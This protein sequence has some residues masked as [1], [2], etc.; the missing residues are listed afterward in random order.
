MW[1]IALGGAA[2]GSLALA[3][4]IVILEPRAGATI[5]RESPS[6]PV[7][8]SRIGF[9]SE[10]RVT[11][12]TGVIRPREEVEL[13][14]RVPGKVVLRAVEVGDKVVKGQVVARLDD[15]D[16]RLQLELSLAE[17]DAAKTDQ[18]RAKADFD[19]GRVLFAKGHIS[20][21][22]LDRLES[23][24]AE[25]ASRADR[26]ARAAELA[27]NQ[28]GYTT[29]LAE[30]DGVVTAT[31]AEEGE[32]V[33]A[34]RPVASVAKGDAADVVFALP[35]QDRALVDT[36]V[37]QAEIWGAE[38]Q[39]YALTLR[40]ISPDVDPTGRTYRVRMA[41]VAP[42]PAV[43]FGRTVTVTLTIGADAPS[44]PVPLAAILNDG[45]GA[46][47]WRIDATGSRVERVDVRL[48]SVQ[49]QVAHVQGGLTDGD[50]I[51]SLGAHKIDPDRP[52]RVVE[53]YAT[54]ES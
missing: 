26:A 19:R 33:S 39:D 30:A 34:G 23:G 27:R 14:F 49:G 5:A 28:L 20:Q 10:S 13:G 2:L 43:A 4:E 40:D 52:V 6:Q 22:A 1:L 47:V 45:S 32:V 17:Q 29:L 21:A 25:A 37:A 53:T 35:E 54:P 38:G 48:V 50:T 3:S 15:T 18:H 42:D 9:H 51:V 12:Y 16:A 24:A 8:V 31:L 7:R 44:A 41:I 36:A 46:A 11:V